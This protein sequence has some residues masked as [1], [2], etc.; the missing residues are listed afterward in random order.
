MNRPRAIQSL[1]VQS[2]SVAPNRETLLRLAAGALALLAATALCSKSLKAADGREGRREAKE[3]DN[4]LNQARGSAE[5]RNQAYQAR[6]PEEAKKAQQAMSKAR[7]N[8]DR[9]RALAEYKEKTMENL[10]SVKEMYAKA[11]E[12][13]KAKEFGQAA[14]L[15]AS[16]AGATVPGAEE[17]AETSRG[18]MFELE[19]I[20]REK[21]KAADDADLKRD[22]TREVDELGYIMREL[23]YTSARET[24]LRRLASLKSRPDV[25]GLVEYA[26]G[27]GMEAE[28]RLA[29]AV[30]KYNDIAANPRYDNTIAALK[31]RRRVETLNSDEASRD[32]LRVEQDA[33]AD[34]EAP[35]LLNSAKNFLSNNMPKQAV[36]K[37]EMLIMKFPET[38]YAEEAKQKLAE[39]K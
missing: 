37:L 24:A 8:E 16:V 17:M 21:L 3:F 32:K 39:I 19:D 6:T 26:E 31:A 38:K 35:I 14:P 1:R 9:K 22:Y 33:K 25:A 2:L 15:Y 20:A 18:R 11:E 5:L 4:R 29:D 13:W 34:K 7:E 12:A 28:G 10:A 27:E 36:E 30:K 23:N